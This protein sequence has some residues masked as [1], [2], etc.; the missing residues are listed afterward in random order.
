MGSYVPV[1][2]ARD[3][4]VIAFW[5]R[6]E[7]LRHGDRTVMSMV[8]AIIASSKLGN[9]EKLDETV[10]RKR[11]YDVEYCILFIRHFPRPLN[12]SCAKTYIF[13]EE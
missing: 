2:K 13:G 6:E 5:E 8:I 10:S 3:R 7:I 12:L 9:Q 1:S 4:Q 11:N